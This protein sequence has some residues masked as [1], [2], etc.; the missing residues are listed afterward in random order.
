MF[1][2]NSPNSATKLN[3]EFRFVKSKEPVIFLFPFLFVLMGF[4]VSS[5]FWV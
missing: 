5:L 1:K 4:F 3:M 2:P